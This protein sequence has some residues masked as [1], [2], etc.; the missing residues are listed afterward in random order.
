MNPIRCRDGFFSSKKHR[1]K[2][3]MDL[4]SHHFP[5][6]YSEGKNNSEYQ[7]EYQKYLLGHQLKQN[8]DRNKLRVTNFTLGEEKENPKSSYE[9]D[10]VQKEK[11]R[12]FS[13]REFEILE[14]TS[15]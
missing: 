6:G 10:Y 14:S 9:K 2:I 4:R 15:F 5:I 8:Y 3:N 12:Q 13:R 11:K 1:E 7:I